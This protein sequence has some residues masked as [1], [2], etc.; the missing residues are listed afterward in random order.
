MPAIQ[1]KKIRITK[2]S[3]APYKNRNYGPYSL[4]NITIYNIGF[5]KMPGGL[6]TVCI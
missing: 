2:L 5:Q 3:Q 6:V 4:K 1:H